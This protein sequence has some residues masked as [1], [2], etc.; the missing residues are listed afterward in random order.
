MNSKGKLERLKAYHEAGHAVV[1]RTLGIAMSYVTTLPTEDMTAGGA[2]ANSASWLARD[3]DQATQLAAI[4]KDMKACLAG[5][6]AQA[7]YQPRKIKRIPIGLATLSWQKA[8]RRRR[9]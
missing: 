2:L 4:E 8:L 9:S 5:P 6:H 7:R 1:A 3:A